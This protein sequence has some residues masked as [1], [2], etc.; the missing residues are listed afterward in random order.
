MVCFNSKIH[1]EAKMRKEA[2]ALKN[3]QIKRSAITSNEYEIVMTGSSTMEKS[4]KEY[5]IDEEKLTAPNLQC[6][7][8][9]TIEQVV[10]E[11]ADNQY[12]NV[13]IKVV[14]VQAPMT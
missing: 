8:E 6:V 5:K 10:N 1:E 9:A 2:V 7:Q 4:D 3:C 11:L 13:V 14:K 12:V